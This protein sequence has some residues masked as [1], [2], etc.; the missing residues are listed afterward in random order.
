MSVH[1]ATNTSLEAAAA[2][3]DDDGDG[4][5]GVYIEALKQKNRVLQKRIAAC[6]SRIMVATVFDDTSSA[7]T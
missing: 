7:I 5:G 2:A 4:D 1:V 3:D 6:H